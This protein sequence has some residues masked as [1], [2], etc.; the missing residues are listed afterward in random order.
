MNLPNYLRLMIGE[1]SAA[2]YVNW[3][4]YIQVQGSDLVTEA[5]L[6][7]SLKDGLLYL[8]VA[9]IVSK[10]IVDWSRVNMNANNSF[11]QLDNCSYLM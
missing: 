7:E 5:N 8:R 2:K 6:L 9:D 10:G 11:R 3:F 1:D 4:K